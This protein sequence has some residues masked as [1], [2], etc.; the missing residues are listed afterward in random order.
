MKFT[1]WVSGR[2]SA[3]RT[4]IASFFSNTKN[5]IKRSY[6]AANTVRILNSWTASNRSADADIYAALDKLRARSRDLADNNEYAKKFMQMVST[7][8]VGPHGFVLQMQVKDDSGTLDQM[9][10]NAIEKSFKRWCRSQFSD[11]SKKTSFVTKT[12]IIIKSVARDGEA[13]VRKVFSSENP[14]GFSLMHVDIDRLDVNRNQVLPDGF[15]IK[16]GVE[17]SP[18]GEVL[19]YHLKMNHPGDTGYSH[20]GQGYDRVP[21]DQIYHLHL[22]DRPEQS[23]GVPWMHAAM[24]KL[25]NLGAFEEAAVIAARIGASKMG[26]FTTP[27]GDGTPLADE[28]NSTTGE[29]IQEAEPGIF[30][31][32]PPGY[33]FKEFSPDYPH[34]NYEGFVKNCLR[35]ISSGMG[36]AYNTIANDLEGVNFS[37]IRAGVLEERDNW[38]VLQNWFIEVFL[39]DVFETWLRYALLNNQIT[40]PNGNSLPTSRFEKFNAPLWVGRRWAWVDPLKD[41][42]AN[43]LAVKHG[44]KSNRQVISSTGDDL[45]DT[46]NELAEEKAKAE[47][48][49]LELG[50][51][52]KVSM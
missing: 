18:I 43:V 29:L 41:M 13:I 30:G 35:G 5:A 11:A 6:A 25:R 24:S 49:N 42:Q 8:V 52:Q 23:R 22:V 4:V 51:Q 33:D 7:H 1:K 36:V 21:A 15:I 31:V 10:N 40:T 39:L 3:T 38:I 27:D 26:F 2:Y 9:A 32:L 16:M 20:N 50:D 28:S 12:R 34:A 45:D 44:F 14:Y 17:M 48:M 46:W 37:S 47:S 19:A